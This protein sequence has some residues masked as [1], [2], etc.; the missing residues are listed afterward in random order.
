MKSRA[1]ECHEEGTD[2]QEVRHEACGLRVCLEA[3]RGDCRAV[4]EAAGDVVVHQRTA[5]AASSIAPLPL[6]QGRRRAC[7]CDQ[8]TDR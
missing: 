4:R 1:E 6:I 8:C 5:V 7:R 2:A 3:G